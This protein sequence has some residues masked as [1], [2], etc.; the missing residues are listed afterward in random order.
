MQCAITPLFF[1]AGFSGAGLG[2]TYELLKHV[3]AEHVTVYACVYVYII[4][5]S[6][7]NSHRVDTIYTI[8]TINQLFLY[9]HYRGFGRN[10]RHN[11]THP[12]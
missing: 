10:I 9:S 5:L 12:G 2:R 8:T 7:V 3:C 1:Y 6:R 4:T 11:S